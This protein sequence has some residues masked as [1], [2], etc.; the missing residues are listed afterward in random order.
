MIYFV[1]GIVV[2]AF[3]VLATNR[4]RRFSRRRKSL[5][6]VTAYDDRIDSLSESAGDRMNVHKA[7]TSLAA[8]DALRA[9]HPE[10]HDAASR[11][12]GWD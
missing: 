11:L 8:R 12:L 1:L 9:N 3:A 7:S 5:K 10:L 4:V 6:A 2:G